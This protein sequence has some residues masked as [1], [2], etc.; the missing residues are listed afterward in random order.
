MRGARLFLISFL[1]LFLEVAL[2]RW[3]PAY[4]RLLSYFSNFILL[5]AFLGI[6]IGCLLT[7]VR[8]VFVWFPAVQALVIAAVYYLRL[9]I[10]VPSSTSIYFSSGTTGPI[11]PIESWMLLPVL[12]TVVAVLFITLAQTLGRAMEEGTQPLVAYAINLAG[13]L[14][15]VVAFA[16]MSYFELTPTAWFGLAFLVALPFVFDSKPLVALV[17]VGLLGVA[18]LFVHLL[19]HGTIWSPYYKITTS[20][21]NNETVVEV[22]NIFHQSMAP[23]TKKEY[24]YQ[25]PYRVLGDNFDDVLI[26]GAGSGTDVAASLLHGTKRID[27]VEIDPVIVRLGREHHPDKPYSDPRVHI[28]TDDARHYLR[29]TD[30]K[31]D[32]V[33][34]ALI[35]SLT[36]QS[37]YTSVR[38]ESYMFTE[39]SFRAVRERLKPGGVLV[40]YNYFRE[41]WLVDRLANTAAAAFEMEPRV[42]THQ[43]HGYLGVMMI[44]PGLSQIQNWPPIPDR[45]EAYNHPDV[46]SPGR[47]LQRDEAVRPATDDWP[48]LYMRYAEIP[49]HYL[50]ALAL[51]L[52]VSV[53]S[54][55]AT[56]RFG[57]GS[58]GA[59]RSG[60]FAWHFFFLGVGFMLLETKSIIQFALLWGSTWVVASLT[61]ASVLTMAMAA[62]WTAAKVDIARPWRVGAVLLALLGASYLLPIG[63]FAFN[64]LVLE[65]AVY[66][67]L[68]FSPIFCAG[69]LFGSSLRRSTTV[70]RDF[71]ANLLGAMLGGVAEYV[72]LMSGFQFL[73]VLIAACYVLALLT[74]PKAVAA[75][76]TSAA[77]ATAQGRLQ[78]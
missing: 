27:A 44:G 56:L 65:S 13:S 9:E 31:Y 50:G 62:T 47:P 7:R 28:V 33:V 48:F 39:E 1:V 78:A 58:G 45:V 63:T 76:A 8:S 29:T 75:T 16:A 52:V 18:L 74:R 49:G 55:G 10:A 61:I 5:A 70:A 69:L 15:G 25:W 41:R 36:L 59:A 35:D 21:A 54:V 66:A 3:M 6:G 4:V 77:R 17:N 57:Q 32:L 24:F 23:V 68:M 73:L 42:H 51:V 30:K 37:G 12:F 43:E 72:S 11:I 20:T 34:F 14:A 71:G 46:I 53:L 22:N 60:G 2:I 67:L 26:L 19:A 64:S 40:V 38:L